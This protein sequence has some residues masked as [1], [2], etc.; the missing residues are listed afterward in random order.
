MLT[1]EDFIKSNQIKQIYLKK[2]KL[3]NVSNLEKFK[4][5][6]VLDCSL[7]Y[8]ETLRF[9]QKFCKLTVLDVSWNQIS[10]LEKIDLSQLP[11]LENLN[12][13]G[14]LI[15]CLQPIPKLAFLKV[16]RVSQNRLERVDVSHFK[17]N[18][19][20]L[21]FLGLGRNRISKF[22]S[23]EMVLPKM[24][25]LVEIDVHGNKLKTLNFLKFFPSVFIVDASSNQIG[26]F[27]FSCIL[28]L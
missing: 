4:A 24:T 17:Q 5:L 20:S 6:E 8:L 14:N 10:D 13:D 27:L 28:Q 9:S 18:L 15:D 11:H 23:S 25:K 26:E 12:L 16:L 21:E 22:W 19:S 2:N 1:E 3:Q 7:N